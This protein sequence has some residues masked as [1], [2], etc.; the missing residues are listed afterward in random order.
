[1]GLAF[2]ALYAVASWL[3]AP[4]PFARSIFGNAALVLTAAIVP[5][6]VAFRRRQWAGCQRLFW[7]VVAIGMVLWIVG[8]T[9]WAYYQLRF[10]QQTWLQWHTLFSLCAGFGPLVALL[11]RP[12]RGIRRDAVAP[13]AMTIAAY[14]LLAV[15]VYSYFVLLPS[16][17]PDA[18]PASQARLLYFVQANRLMLLIAVGASFWATIKSVRSTTWPGSRRGCVTPGRR[19]RRRRRLK[20]RAISSRRTR[21]PRWGCWRCRRC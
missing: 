18:R 4:Y 13:I 2:I 3:L 15:F 12:H 6:I 16:L 20:K 14:C 11:A 1:M 5:I 19:S 8:H 10:E 17:V 7:D 9:G 21:S